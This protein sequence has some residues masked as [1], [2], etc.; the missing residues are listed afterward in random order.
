[1]N[2]DAYRAYFDVSHLTEGTGK[3]AGRAGR[4]VLIIAAFKLVAHLGSTI[5]LARLVPPAEFGIAALAMPI[6]LVAISLSQF[7][8]AQPIVQR[9]EINHTLVNS[10]FW[11]NTGL[12]LAFGGMVALLAWPAAQFYGEPKVGP[13]FVALGLSVVSASILTQYVALLRRRM[14]IR[15]LELIGLTSFLASILIAVVAAW[16]GASYWAIVLQ[17]MLQSV[18]MV[19]ILAARSPWRPSGLRQTDFRAARSALSFGGN[20]ALH[21][22]LLQFL[23]MFPVIMLGRVSGALDTG[24]Y[25]RSHTLANLLPARLVEPLAGVF[26]P[27]L[28]R[29]YADPMA[30]QALFERMTTRIS[31]LVMPVGIILASCADLLV[32][33]LLGPEWVATAPV[34][35]WM[36]VLLF[37]SPAL[38]GLTWAMI[39]AAAS[40][41]LMISGLIGAGVV[42]CAT[43]LSV[44]QPVAQVAAT[45]MLSHLFLALPV[46]GMLAVS[47]TPLTV[48]CLLRACV[49]DLGLAGVILLVLLEARVLLDWSGWAEFAMC[50]A[51][52][53]AAYGLRVALNKDLRRDLLTF[54]GRRLGGAP[55]RAPEP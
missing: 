37:Q 26:V 24:L 52:V 15:A 53:L 45:V 49:V 43:L 39:A 30:F 36:S 46:M 6:V 12:G 54:V 3:R 55:A 13:V 20:V 2:S 1:M 31:L 16:L 35:A 25:Y 51:V 47:K 22:L 29:T 34:M 50:C 40:R 14:E 4:L 32:P 33:T 5:V 42:V 8:L 9:S 38:Q 44:G 18:F 19:L 11:A 48:L 17:H 41:R 10:L 21:S 28:S 27:S 7:G 23:Q